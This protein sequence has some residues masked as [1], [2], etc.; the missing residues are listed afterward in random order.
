MSGRLGFF[1]LALSSLISLAMMNR[2]RS[3]TVV[4]TCFVFVQGLMAFIPV[5]IVFMKVF[6][7]S[8]IEY[9]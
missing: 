8:F 6:T 3:Q 4:R 2:L 7:L 9:L 1:V 5:F